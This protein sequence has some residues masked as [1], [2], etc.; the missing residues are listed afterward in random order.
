[1][2]DL[3]CVLAFAF[4]SLLALASLELRMKPTSPALSA[5]RAVKRL[6]VVVL[7]YSHICILSFLRTLVIRMR[8]VIIDVKRSEGS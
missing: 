1:M 3:I 6:R 2:F 7:S 8:G 4:S 5:C